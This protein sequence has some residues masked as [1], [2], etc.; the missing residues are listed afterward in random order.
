MTEAPSILTYYSII[1]RDGVCLA[2]LI[3][4]IN[5]L[6]IMACDVRNAYFNEPCQEK[7]WF[8]AG[9]DNGQ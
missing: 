8:A 3:A 6:D 9:P 1:T 4:G 2:F 7:I 5:D